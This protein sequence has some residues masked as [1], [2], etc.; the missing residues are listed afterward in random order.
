MNLCAETNPTKSNMNILSQR[1]HMNN[2][3]D[4]NSVGLLSM[5]YRAQM[6]HEQMHTVT[7]VCNKS[8]QKMLHLFLYICFLIIW[9]L[10]IQYGFHEKS[11][12]KWS[13][14][15][16]SFNYWTPI[17]EKHWC[18]RKSPPEHQGDEMEGS[19]YNNYCFFAPCVLALCLS[20][21]R[22]SHCSQDSHD[23]SNVF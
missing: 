17:W 11:A 10:P 19:V 14:T 2:K 12:R 4:A 3:I 16:S 5:S 22:V 9:Q 23:D 6:W 7:A 20:S 15:T 13:W 18:G 21:K 8:I 1:K